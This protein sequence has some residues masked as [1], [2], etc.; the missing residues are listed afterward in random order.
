MNN[1]IIIIPIL[2]ILFFLLVVKRVENFESTEPISTTNLAKLQNDIVTAIGS[3]NN[4]QG[5]NSS[6]GSSNGNL[7]IKNTQLERVAREVA[8][9]YCPCDKDFDMDDYVPKTSLKDNCPKVPNLDDYIHKSAQQPQQ[10]CPACIC[11][12]IDLKTPDLTESQCKNLFKKCKDN[13]SF[14]KSLD[15]HI[16][17]NFNKPICPKAPECPNEEK[18]RENLMSKLKCPPPAPCPVY[19]DVLPLIMNLLE[20]KTDENVVTLNRVKE[21]LKDKTTTLAP[22]TTLAP[23]TTHGPTT[24]LAPVTTLAPTT[25]KA[26]ATTLAPTTTK[27]QVT[28]KPETTTTKMG[29]NNHNHYKNNNVTVDPSNINS[30]LEDQRAENMNYNGESEDDSNGNVFFPAS[31]SDKCKS[32]PLRI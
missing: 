29:M 21:L 17:D 23:T 4:D 12:T 28:Y 22:V 26:P 1:I 15:E 13:K 18:I 30:L 24:T 11:P 19:K 3:E 32:L 20:N 10:K 9:E 16:V 2:V 8:R 14:L 31:N 5:N 25:T 6:R 27:A 7:N